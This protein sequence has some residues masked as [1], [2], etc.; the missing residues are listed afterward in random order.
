MS[1]TRREL[2][3]ELRDI[4]NGIQDLVVRLPVLARKVRDLRERLDVPPQDDTAPE[5]EP[6]QEGLDLENT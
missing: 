3:A 1:V 2:D 4:E 5:P 6:V